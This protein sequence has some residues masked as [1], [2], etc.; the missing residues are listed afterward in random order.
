MIAGLLYFNVLFFIFKCGVWYC[1]NC[2]CVL[3][4]KRYGS[5]WVWV[6]RICVLFSVAITVAYFVD[7]HLEEI[8]FYLK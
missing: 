1:Y 8:L 6:V 3:V 2:V 5:V 4:G 7:S